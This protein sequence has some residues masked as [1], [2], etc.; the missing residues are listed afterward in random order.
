[1]SKCPSTQPPIGGSD[2]INQKLSDNWI[3]FIRLWFIWLL[4]IWHNSRCDSTHTYT[5]PPTPTNPYAT[6]THP[7][8]H[9]HY[10][11]QPTPTHPYTYP[12]THTPTPIHLHPPTPCTY[13]P[14]HPSTPYPPTPTPTYPPLEPTHLHTPT[15]TPTHPY[16]YPLTPT[17]TWLGRGRWMQGWVGSC[18]WVGSIRWRFTQFLIIWH[19]PTHWPTHPLNH[20][21]IH[22]SKGGS[23]STNHKSSNRIELSRLD[24]IL[25]K[26]LW[27][28]IFR[29]T[30]PPIH[31]P[32]KN[33]HPWVGNFSTD[34]KSSNGIE[35]SWFIQV[36]SHF[37]WFGGVP[38]WGVDGW[39]GGWVGAPPM[40]VH[41]C[42][43]THARAHTHACMLNMI[44][45]AASMVA[46]ICNFLTCLSSCFVHVHACMC[47]CTC[48]G[49]PPMPSYAPPTHLPPHQSRREPKSP[50][51]YKSWTNRDN[52]ILFEKSLSLNILELI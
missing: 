30:N 26:F 28:H 45:M 15:P 41:T 43:H 10:N 37:Y 38:P 21:P 20:L 23:V 51:V 14:L 17:P 36:L 19:Q 9:L 34:S 12:P 46:A 1:M 52:S 31:P 6:P 8:L 18:M 35:I 44:N 29:P 27:F 32:T 48:L 22:L 50:K 16:T 7:P 25:L 24:Q 49:T 42:T 13:P 11:N 47:V 5:Y 40:H 4:V 3:I 33:T 39:V 2:S